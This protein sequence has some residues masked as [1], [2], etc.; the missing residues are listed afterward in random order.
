MN[1]VTAPNGR[2]YL[3]VGAGRRLSPDWTNLDLARAPH[4]QRHDLRRPLPFADGT[5]DAVYSSHVLEH[6]ERDHAPRVLAE[7]RRV[8][9]PGGIVRV[10]VP[11]LERICRDYIERLDA[12]AS[13]D[14]GDAERRRFDWIKLELLDQ[15]V[16]SKS[17]GRMLQAV[18]AR[19]VD[20]DDVV[21]RCGDELA[22]AAA[23][24]APRPRLG[25]RTAA[26]ALVGRILPAL[27]SPARTGELHRWMYDRVELA[28]LLREAG[29][30]SPRVVDHE[31]SAVPDWELFR[32]DSSERG[33]GP[34][35]PD[36]LYMEAEA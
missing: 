27:R 12:A 19:E 15:M 10:V 34:R 28:Q 18:R 9:K 31:E 24:S 13:P 6:L 5:F 16:R 25:P 20:A 8:L 2:R 33:P 35:K 36:S 3:N 4:V 21:A 32:L 17:G 26:S 22:D 23:G 7:M 1:P 11:D 14:A 30:S 29:F